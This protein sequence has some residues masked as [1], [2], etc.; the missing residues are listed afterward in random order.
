M[1]LFIP[2]S[3]KKFVGFFLDKRENAADN[4]MH[5]TIP[6]FKIMSMEMIIMPMV[7]IVMVIMMRIN[8]MMKMKMMI[9]MTMMVVV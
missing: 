7:V 2:H 1:L 9:M 4:V 5:M 8:L 3:A 6:V